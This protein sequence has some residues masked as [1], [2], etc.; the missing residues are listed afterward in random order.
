M[1]WAGT[2]HECARTSSLRHV[3]QES[4]QDAVCSCSM[5]VAMGP[6]A[7]SCPRLGAAPP[8]TSKLVWPALPASVRRGD[9]RDVHP[10]RRPLL[11][12]LQGEQRGRCEARRFS[13]SP[14]MHIST[15]LVREAIRLTLRVAL[16]L[17]LRL[18]LPHRPIHFMH[19]A[20]HTQDA[21]RQCPPR[22]RAAASTRAPVADSSAR[23]S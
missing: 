20:C 5:R 14:A 10:R 12:G 7:A 13:L 4:C 1:A 17:S 11:L 23:R 21:S 22:R 19:S 9:A 18:S 6:D 2:G 8:R 16:G 15:R 3:M